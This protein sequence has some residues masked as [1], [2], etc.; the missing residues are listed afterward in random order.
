MAKKLN[1]E[2]LI[3][4]N[5]KLPR[6]SKSEGKVLKLLI[7]AVKLVAP[8]YKQQENQK[9]PGANFYPHDVIREEIE[10][11]AK[12]NP[13]ILSRYTVV[14]RIDG[15]LVAIPYHVK[16][17][18]FL[19]PIADKLNKAG[20]ITENRELRRFLKLQARALLEGTY[21]EAIVAGL[22]MK[23]YILDISIG[24]IDHDDDLL[25]FAKASY[26]A[27]VGVMDE[28]GTERLNNYKS[29]IFSSKR[30]SVSTEWVDNY[31]KVK[32]KVLDVVVFS[33]LLAKTKFVGLNLPSN[34]NIVEKYGSEVTLFN[35][36]NDLRMR[37]QI[38]PTFKKIFSQEF[39]HSFDFEDLRRGNLRYIAMHELS[40]SYLYYRHAEENLQ[41]LFMPIYE[42]AATVL[43]FRMAGTLLLK[44][45]I[46]DKQLESMIVA[47]LCRSFYLAGQTQIS[48]SMAGYTLGSTIFINFLLESGALKAS[49][50]IATPNYMKVFIV[51][52]D[53]FHTLEKLLSS[54]TRK[55]A[56]ALI[57][58][59]EE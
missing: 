58:K 24:P 54:G 48:K 13:E 28:E 16:Y 51:L 4:F 52:P 18:E 36:S 34:I 8:L 56:A 22:A 19:K 32:A 45:R 39:R 33:G 25:F 38:M 31:G 17:R 57:K 50:G 2:T 3:E 12:S 26:Q 42:L 59:Y 6:L 15:K 10:E 43:G 35:Q 46:N 11:A 21:Q 40:H 37:E 23:P 14:E 41:D 55:E 30:G 53:L 7:E 20:E 5:P 49:R 27:W 47:F 9:F 44:D 29:I 1:Q